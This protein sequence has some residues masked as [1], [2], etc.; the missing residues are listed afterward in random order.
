MSE[1]GS[2]ISPTAQSPAVQETKDIAAITTLTI[3]QD[4][5][6]QDD[7]S[8]SPCHLQRLKFDYGV[9]R[10]YTASPILTFSS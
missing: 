8:F 10:I 4:A 2:H 6:V 9:S 1:K 3:E 7:D 5:T